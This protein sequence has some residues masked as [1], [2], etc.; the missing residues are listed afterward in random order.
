MRLTSLYTIMTDTIARGA[1][2]M[3]TALVIMAG[4][5]S[6]QEPQRI[7]SIGGAA[8]EIL[9]DL[10]LA[11]KIAA[12][13]TTSI[14]P[15]EALQT[16]PNVGY[17][18]ALSAEGVLA[19]QPD[20]ILMEDGAGPP[21][22]IALLDQARIKVVHI[23]AGHDISELSK[24]I[25]T[26]ADAVGKTEEGAAMAARAESELEK[27]KSDLTKLTAKKRVLF[28]LSLVDGRPMAAGSDTGADSMITLAGAENVFKDV[29]GY[30]TISPEAATALQPDVV[31]M[32]T[33][34]G[35][36]HGGEDVLKQPAFS[37]TPAGK[38]GGFILMDALYLLGFGPRTPAA[39]RD[40]AA[41]LYPDL[42]LA[43]P[44]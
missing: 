28:V 24:K 16:K 35:P 27:L 26:I 19:T 22:A 39:A 6:A 31:L 18:R 23:P 30:K 11:E 43:A 32:I 40:L 14:H 17:L 36:M 1:L 34:G 33:R 21:E 20:L 42:S 25:R 5:A 7:V 29:K 38:N 12:V 13:D 41:K 44:Q 3:A 2:W 10:G 15:P 9:Y 4:A 37:E 8:T